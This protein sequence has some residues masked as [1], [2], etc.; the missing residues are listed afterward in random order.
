MKA[1][2]THVLAVVE[3]Q[4]EV[5]VQPQQATR[6]VKPC[7]VQG[8]SGTVAHEARRLEGCSRGAQ[9]RLTCGRE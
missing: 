8:L 2:D 1:C 5:R 7:N 4:A 6:W 9:V 3:A